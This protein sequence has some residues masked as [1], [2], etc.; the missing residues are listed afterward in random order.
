MRL[1]GPA[2]ISDD[3]VRA[4]RG[5]RLAMRAGWRLHPDAEAAIEAAAHLITRVAAERV[6]DELVGI[7]AEPAAAAGLRV[8]DRLGVLAVLLPESL[9]M[10]AT[11]QPL[12]HHF[13]VWEHSLRAVEGMD[14]LLAGL[15]ALAPWGP[16]LRE[17]LMLD[18]GGGLT[19]REA[20]KLAA[21]LHDVAKPETRAEIGGRIRFIGHDAAGARRAAGIAAALPS[22]AARRAGARAARGRAP[23]AHASGAGGRRHAPRAVSLLPGARRRGARSAAAGAG[24]RGGARRRLPAGGLG[25]LRR[26]RWC[27]P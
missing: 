1:C 11:A 23:A 16:A 26:R 18:L 4:L 14:A 19:R 24:R 5:V 8:L 22:L 9:P 2:A 3:P 20:L 7:L 13:D 15:D 21:L 12:P 27:A 17:H 25:G 6:R 10:R